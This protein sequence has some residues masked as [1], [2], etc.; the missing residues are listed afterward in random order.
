MTLFTRTYTTT[1]TYNGNTYTYTFGN[2]PATKAILASTT[3]G[4]G[5]FGYFGG[6]RGVIGAAFEIGS[7]L[8]FGWVNVSAS[9]AA[10]VWTIHGYA[11]E[12]Q[13]NTPI[14]AIPKPSSLALL[15]LGA[16]GLSVWWR[17]Q[18]KKP[19]AESEE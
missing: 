10:D 3:N 15:A 2:T 4:Y 14:H 1:T 18:Q 16:A 13:A 11:Y 5:P 6:G 9:P 7:N 19:A 12:D 8:H 17:R